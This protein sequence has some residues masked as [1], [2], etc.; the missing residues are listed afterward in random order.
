MIEGKS[1]LAILPARGGSKGIPGKNIKLLGNKPLIAW[2]IEAAKNSRYIDRIV[3][4]TDSN[5]IADVSRQFGADVPFMRPVEL[6]SDSAKTSD[7]IIHAIK[8]LSENDKA[9]YDYFVLLQ[10]TSPLR[11]EIHIDKSIETIINDKNA[12]S[13]VS[14]REVK[15]NPHLMKV[16]SEDGYLD[17][18][19]TTDKSDNRRQDLPGVY[20]LNGA[21]YISKT[22]EYLVNPSFY[23]GNCL[24]FV[25]NYESSID[26][27]D[28]TDFHLAEYLLNKANVK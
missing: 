18:L 19:I 10:P 28:I 11:N 23:S 20:I 26:I 4:S 14:V 17:N 16:I 12:G 21:I 2:T 27:D 24:P 5:E 7:A 13:L 6:A 15:E 22:D 1:F 9:N 8:W 3:I 25:M